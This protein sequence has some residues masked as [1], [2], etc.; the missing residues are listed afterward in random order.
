MEDGVGVQE[1][2]VEALV[3][4]E[5]PLL[6]VQV[7]HGEGHGRVLLVDLAEDAAA[8]LHL[9]LVL[10]VQRALVHCRL[11]LIQHPRLPLP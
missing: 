6:G 5:A 7:A 9:Q 8:G 11:L 10:L 3:E 4:T 1:A 2:V